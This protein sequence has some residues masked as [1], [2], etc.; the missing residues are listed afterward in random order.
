VEKLS[1]N[2]R[3]A[4]FRS[5]G[6]G[7]DE[8]GSAVSAPFVPPKAAFQGRQSDLSDSF[9]KGNSPKFAKKGPEITHLGEAPAS[10]PLLWF[11][12]TRDV[13]SGTPRQMGKEPQ[14]P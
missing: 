3:S 4:P 5:S 9:W 12:K 13:S 6:S 1:D 14:A 2:S 7:L 10:S 11:S 8:A